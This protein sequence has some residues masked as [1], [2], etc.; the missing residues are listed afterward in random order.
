VITAG[1]EGGGDWIRSSNLGDHE[2]G[3]VSA[4]AEWRQQA[5]SRT[6]V[7][8][9]VRVD[10]YSQFGTAM[11][12]SAGV[13]FSVARDLRLRA[14]AGRAFRVPTFTERFYSDP[15]NLARPEVGPETAWSGEAGVD[16]F[17]G[18][19]WIVTAT[20]FARADEE[21]IDW[22]RRS[23]AE[24]WRTYN[25]RDVDT[26]GIEL[27]LRGSLG[28]AAFIQAGYT[29]LSVDAAAIDQLSKYVLDYAS[30]SFTAAA[31]LPLR[32][33]FHLAP[34]LEYRRRIRAAGT[35]DDVLLDLRVGRRIG[36][37]FELSL[38]GTNLFDVEYQEVA[39]VRMPGAALTVSLAVR[40]P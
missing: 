5:G 7:E 18:P 10:R 30:R 25:I 2:L 16:L 12:P 9:G 3:R 23:T 34:R 14:S 24:R 31:S 38:E 33:S 4:F 17:A 1:V 21:V 28:D 22:L 40:T 8:G 27:G 26:L 32:G 15:A 36:R 37:F 6:H 29:G 39:G 35:S 11:S 19:R 20:A 13:R